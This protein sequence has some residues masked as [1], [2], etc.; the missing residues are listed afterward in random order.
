MYVTCVAT[1]SFFTSIMS[2]LRLTGCG[3]SNQWQ[4]LV[5]DGNERKYEL[6]ETKILGYIKLKGLKEIFIVGE[7]SA[8]KNQ[9]VYAELVQY[10]DERSLSL[11]MRD[12]KEHAR[13]ALRILRAH[14][15]G[16]GK[17]RFITLYN[18]FTTL[19]KSHSEAITDYI[20][21][22]ENAATA[23]NAADEVVSDSLFVAMVLNGLPNDYKVFEAMIT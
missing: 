20:I 2:D 9:F 11:V 4:N 8:D 18:Q 12:A 17:P 22:V 14:Y 5:F 3:P 1:R 15:A 13:E 10:L 23:L 6:W 16:S 7:I 19:N 21:R